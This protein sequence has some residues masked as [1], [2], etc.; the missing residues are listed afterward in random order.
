MEQVTK[1]LDFAMKMELQARDFYL[2]SLDEVKM[3][4][5]RQ[6]LAYLAE[7]EKAHYDF[8]KKQKESV[9]KSSR[10]DVDAKPSVD[11]ETGEKIVSSKKEGTSAVPPIDEFA[12]DMGV[13]RV[14]LAMETDFHNF[15]KNAAKNMEDEEGR[16]VLEMLA[17]WES[18]HQTM[19][20]EQYSALHR[21][22][23]AEM[24]FEPF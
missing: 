6:L 19:I 3:E 23:M 8:L 18:E 5:T 15:Y 16:K 14:A 2:D 4:T 12:E 21:D 13:L 11:E 1:I 24:G 10:W 17:G 22:F 9:E 20:N 7:W